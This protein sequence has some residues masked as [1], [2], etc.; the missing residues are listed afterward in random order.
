MIFVDL[1]KKHV[2]G[3]LKRKENLK[4]PASLKDAGI[5]EEAFNKVLEQ[6]ADDAMKSGNIAVNPRKTERT[7]I[8]KIYRD[9]F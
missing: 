6:M 8:L 3:I 7:D 1:T 4:I 5:S 9:S 2:G